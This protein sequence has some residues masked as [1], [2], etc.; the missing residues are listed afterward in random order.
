MIANSDCSLAKVIAAG[1]QSGKLNLSCRGIVGEIPLQLFEPGLPAKT[2]NVSLDRDHRLVEA[3]PAKFLNSEDA[4]WWELT[5]I[6]RLVVSDNE[7]NSLANVHLLNALAVL[8][9]HNNNIHKIPAEVSQLGMLSVLNLS[10]NSI[11]SLPDQLFDCPLVELYLSHNKL[12]NIPSCIRNIAGKLSVLD[13]A[14]NEISDLGT[15]IP[16]LKRLTRLDASS[17]RLVSLGYSHDFA[18]MRQLQALDL[19]KNQIIVLFKDEGGSL[20]LPCL[21]RLDLGF[22]HLRSL[23]IFMETPSL[24]DLSCGFNRLASVGPDILESCKSTLESLDMRDNV[25]TSVPEAVI[26]MTKLKRYYGCKLMSRLD[27]TNNDIKSLAPELGLIQTLDS[28][29]AT[30]NPLRGYPTSGGTGRLLQY[31]RDKIPAIPC[32]E[33]LNE[34]FDE[35]FRQKIVTRHLDLRG[36]GLVEFTQKNVDNA[37]MRGIAL[38]SLTLAKNRLSSLSSVLV[39]SIGKNLQT[40]ELFDNC[41]TEFPCLDLPMLRS[42]D[43]SRNMITCIPAS[44]SGYPMLNE[45][46][47]S[48]NRLKGDFPHQEFCAQFPQLMTVMAPNNQFTGISVRYG[49]VESRVQVLDLSNNSISRL[50]GEI[51]LMTS[52]KNLNIEGNMI[53]VPRRA[54]IDRGTEAIKAYLLERM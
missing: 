24:C 36:R 53:K 7:I 28:L 32:Q 11:A 9:A 12:T 4:A 16:M 51:G 21:Q 37:G 38:L 3:L 22:N 2:V 30:G 20:C 44:F 25:L 19:S 45:L 23:S 6:R 40:L 54:I 10:G 34:D 47:L 27:L 8:D 26:G 41:L 46:F 5:D 35:S 43:L 14:D 33:D 31:L 29:C 50:P 42:L 1:R 48:Q 17:N 39:E 15:G 52:L 18:E 49:L 13:I